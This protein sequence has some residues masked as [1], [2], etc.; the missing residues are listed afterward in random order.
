MFQ[1]CV[2]FYVLSTHVQNSNIVI[3]NRSFY[4]I[5]RLYMTINICIIFL[6]ISLYVGMNYG[7]C[8]IVG[9]VSDH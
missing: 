2:S 7:L 9:M 6:I 8:I 4:I 5:K 3:K 1:V